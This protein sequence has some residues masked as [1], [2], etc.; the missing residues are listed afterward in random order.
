MQTFRQIF[1]VCSDNSTIQERMTDSDTGRHRPMSF[2]VVR[3]VT[4][5]TALRLQNLLVVLAGVCLPSE[6]DSTLL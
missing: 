1:V 5:N 3:S 6:P 4:V 2:D